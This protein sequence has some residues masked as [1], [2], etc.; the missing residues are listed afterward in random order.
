MKI[1]EIRLIDRKQMV[2][3]LSI[4]RELLEMFE[5]IQISS[6][7]AGSKNKSD[8]T[9]T[10]RIFE[11]NRYDCKEF[12]INYIDT[13]DLEEFICLILQDLE[14]GNYHRMVIA[15][16]EERFIVDLVESNLCKCFYIYNNLLFS[17]KSKD[18]IGL[19][20]IEEFQYDKT[21]MMMTVKLCGNEKFK[22]DFVY[23]TIEFL[24]E[25]EC[26]LL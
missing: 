3:V 5:K 26:E 12:T 8:R 13:Y 22:I 1:K 4:Q 18:Y 20:Y 14:N 23:E 7:G 24:N 9:I 17:A 6:S 2:M 19:N 25:A 10:V 11:Y 15:S 16:L 21:N